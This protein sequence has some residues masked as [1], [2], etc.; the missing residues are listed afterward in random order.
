MAQIE[1]AS[2]LIQVRTNIAP[3]VRARFDRVRK[4]VRYRN[5]GD[6]V[7]TPESIGV[8]EGDALAAPASG[9]A[10]AK[11]PNVLAEDTWDLFRVLLR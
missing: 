7:P 3:E 1:R 2:E 5:T 6:T 4:L 10:V 9:A 8:S 11:L